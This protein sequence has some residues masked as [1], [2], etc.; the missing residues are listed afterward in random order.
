MAWNSVS[1]WIIYQDPAKKKEELKQYGIYFDD[2]Y[3]Y[4]QHLRDV[5]LTAEWELAEDSRNGRTFKAP[6]A[7]GISSDC[8]LKLPSSVFQSNVEEEVGLLNRAAPHSGK[9][10]FLSCALSNSFWPTVVLHVS[11]PR[12]DLD[13]D[14]VAA[15]DEDFDFDDPDNELE[16][17]FI[18]IANGGEGAEEDFDG[19][20]DTGDDED[21][22]DEEDDQLADLGSD[23]DRFSPDLQEETKS[24]FTEYSMTSSVMR[25]NQQLSLLDDRFEQV[26]QHTNS[27]FSR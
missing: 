11:G 22:G 27:Y 23:C 17:D 18:M 24:R 2:D 14:I 9:P 20:S 1:Y 8:K 4:L 25:R 3:D 13:P 16:D 6:V 19:D 10:L 7:K 21:D 5:N 15:L 12:P 26:G